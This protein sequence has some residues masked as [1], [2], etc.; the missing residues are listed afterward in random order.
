MP[1]ACRAHR[2]R[3]QALH[4]SGRPVLAPGHRRSP[5]AHARQLVVDAAALHAEAKH[6]VKRAQKNLRARA[7]PQR[8]DA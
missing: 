5:V 7:E 4:D 3:V 8:R 2:R 6:K 1:R